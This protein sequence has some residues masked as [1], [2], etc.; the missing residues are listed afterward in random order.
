[1]EI[2]WMI[3]IAIAIIILFFAWKE[4]LNYE[5]VLK[6]EKESIDRIKDVLSQ[7]EE[8]LNKIENARDKISE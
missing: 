8:L 7:E 5:K 2:L 6:I 4:K 1:M 3:T